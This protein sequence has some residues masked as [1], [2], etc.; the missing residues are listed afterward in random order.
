MLCL[1]CKFKY[2]EAIVIRHTEAYEAGGDDVDFVTGLIDDSNRYFN[3]RYVFGTANGTTTDVAAVTDDVIINLTD[4]TGFVQYERV[5]V[6]LDNGNRHT[7]FIKEIDVGVSI[8]L[9]HGI[10]SAVGVGN[11]VVSASQLEGTTDGTLEEDFKDVRADDVVADSE[12]LL[13]VG[14]DFEGDRFPYTGLY[15]P[16]SRMSALMSR[17]R[18]DRASANLTITNVTQDAESVVTV[19]GMEDVLPF[20]TIFIT[21][22]VGMTELNNGIYYVGVVDGSTFELWSF[23][24][25]QHVDTSG[26]TAY[27]SGGLC[28]KQDANAYQGVLNVDGLPLVISDNDEF[29]HLLQAYSYQLAVILG[30]DGGQTDLIKQISV[31]DNTQAAMDAISDTRDTH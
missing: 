14:Y 10:S 30:N 31:A 22:V 23:P 13:E 26:F 17:Y 29:A 3:E 6:E 24:D 8:T 7:T 21:G 1:H 19:S 5:A 2:N 16:R 4:T 20:D 18:Q 15:E 27:T 25:A 9:A 28:I 12:D 11:N